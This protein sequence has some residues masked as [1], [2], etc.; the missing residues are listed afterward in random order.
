MKQLPDCSALDSN[1]KAEKKASKTCDPAPNS[2]L[3]V[4]A[5]N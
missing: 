3:P 2:N 4:F 5:L 1:S